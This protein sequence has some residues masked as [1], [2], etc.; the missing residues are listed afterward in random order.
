LVFTF[1]KVPETRGRTF[2]DITRAFEGQAQEASR[3][4]KGPGEINSGQPAKEA[5][6]NV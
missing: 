6:T 4:G 1:F 2:D 5:T 3:S